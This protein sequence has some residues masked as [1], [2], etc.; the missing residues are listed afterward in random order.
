MGEKKDHKFHFDTL[1]LHAGHTPDSTTRARAVLIVASTSFVFDD[2][3][4]ASDLL[5]FRK[6]GFVYSRYAVKSHI[7]TE[8]NIDI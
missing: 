5:E 2:F 7:Y 8:T 4:H 3:K 1:Q 6:K